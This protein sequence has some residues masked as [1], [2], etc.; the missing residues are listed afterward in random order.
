M[1]VAANLSFKLMTITSIGHFFRA[2]PAKRFISMII[3]LRA[4]EITAWTGKNTTFCHLLTG[5]SYYD[6]PTR[7]NSKKSFNASEIV[8]NVGRVEII[9]DTTVDFAKLKQSILVSE[10]LFSGVGKIFHFFAF[11]LFFLFFV[12][13]LCV[14]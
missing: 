12:F 13:L 5:K 2:K 6:G 9:R 8:I 1:C 4:I 14:Q 7:R 10:I 3:R 11:L